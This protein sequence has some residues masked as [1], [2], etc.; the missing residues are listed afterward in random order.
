[1]ATLN[2]TETPINKVRYREL[3]Q[4]ISD[5][6]EMPFGIL[7]SMD[8]PNNDTCHLFRVT[9]LDYE[10]EALEIQVWLDEIGCQPSLRV[11]LSDLCREGVLDSGEYLIEVCW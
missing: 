11:L 10:P 8:Y 7:E 3:E 1:M 4:F 6:Y 2:I 9:P 5:F